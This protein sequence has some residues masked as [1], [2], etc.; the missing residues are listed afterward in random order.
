MEK[1]VQGCVKWM[2]Q[3]D[4]FVISTYTH[5]V[6]SGNRQDPLPTSGLFDTFTIFKRVVT[7]GAGPILCVQY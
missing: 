1:R 6:A 5:P 3:Y 7:P 2:V 4:G